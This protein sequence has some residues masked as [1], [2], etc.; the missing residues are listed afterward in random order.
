MFGLYVLQC[1]YL[2]LKFLCPKAS[3]YFF[4]SIKKRIF[5]IDGACKHTGNCC[6]SIMLYHKGVPLERISDFNIFS[7]VFTEYQVFQPNHKQGDIYS[8]SCQALTKENKCG[9]YMA[10]PSLCRQ[11]P[12]SFF[13]THGYIYDSCGYYISLNMEMYNGLLPVVKDEIDC[14]YQG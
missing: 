13:F 12:Q 14:F 1:S 10:R 2:V 9:Q 4:E 7:K 6:R 3:H 8:F 5:L 11:Y